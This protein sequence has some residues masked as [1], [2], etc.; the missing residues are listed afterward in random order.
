MAISLLSTN[1]DNAAYFCLSI[2]NRNWKRETSDTA[3]MAIIK[4]G[5]FW[6][7]WSKGCNRVRGLTERRFAEQQDWPGRQREDD[8]EQLVGGRVKQTDQLTLGEEED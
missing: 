5:N 7:L 4:R 1:R 6:S 2:L 3:S 8:G